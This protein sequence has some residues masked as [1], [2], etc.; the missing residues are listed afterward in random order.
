MRRSKL[1]T[2]EGSASL[3]FIT[4][5][6]LL[7]LPVVY[8]VLV[9]AAVQAGA[10]AV[11]GAARQAARV[12]VQGE[13]VAT[14]TAQ[15]ERAIQFALADYGL[16]SADATVAVSCSPDPSRCLTRL[17]TVTFDVGV[18]VA[19]PLVPPGLT[20]DAPLAIPLEATA[21]Q[22]VSRFWSGR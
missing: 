11:E 20:I 14:A 4:A 17:G 8:L 21:T 1:S 19:L 13:T 2:E 6:M 3:E 7:L 22:P 15:A 10:L 18:S 5:G 16:D 9:M 12:F